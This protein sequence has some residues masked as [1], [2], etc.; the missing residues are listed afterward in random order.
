MGDA[1]SLALDLIP[2]CGNRRVSMDAITVALAPADVASTLI[3]VARFC[4]KSVAE[5]TRRVFEQHPG[6]AHASAGRPSYGIRALCT[7]EKCV[8][9]GTA[10]NVCLQSE[11]TVISY[12]A[13]GAALWA[14]TGPSGESLGTVALCI[15]ESEVPMQVRVR[16]V[17]GLMN[18][19][20]FPEL[21]ALAQALAAS[22]GV[23]ERG[24]WI[25]YASQCR[26]LCHSAGAA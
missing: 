21:R 13:E 23:A 7:L 12:I 15:D 18:A 9:H 25:E 2:G 22:F 19:R 5:M 20:V 4:E 10:C 1:L 17:T 14:V 8:E 3:Q 24:R 6:L 16:Q 11:S 26:A